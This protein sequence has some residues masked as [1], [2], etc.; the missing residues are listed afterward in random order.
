[1]AKSSIH[2]ERASSGGTKHND[3]TQE[4][5]PD[6]LLPRQYRLKNEVD[7]SAEEAEQKI[8][9]LY[10]TA[11]KN[12][13]KIKGQKLQAT[14]Y[15]WEAVVN[16]NKYHTM[17]DVQQLA[18]ELEKETGFTAVQVAIHRD[19]GRVERGYPIHNFHAHITFFTLNLKNGEQLYRK[20]IKSSERRAIERYLLERGIDKGEPRSR[21]R[22]AFNN[23]VSKEIEARGIKVMDKKR[24]SKL[25]DLT[26]R[27]LGMIRGKRGSNAVRLEHKAYKAKKRDEDKLLAKEIAKQ[28]DL[29][30]EVAQLRKE[31]QEQGAIR[32]DYARLEQLNR[33]LKEQV[34]SKNLTI[35]ELG[36]TVEHWKNNF[37][38]KKIENEKALSEAQE[39][40]LELKATISSEKEE[41]E[42]L[43]Q[44]I[45]RLEY[46]NSSNKY[47]L[48]ADELHIRKIERKLALTRA[49]STRLMKAIGK[50][51][52]RIKKLERKLKSEESS[53]SEALIL[54]A[55]RSE[56]DIQEVEKFMRETSF[57]N[58]SLAKFY[59]SARK[60]Y[61][62]YAKYADDKLLVEDLLRR[63]FD[64]RKLKEAVEIYEKDLLKVL[65]RKAR[66]KSQ[67]FEEDF[68]EEISNSP[69]F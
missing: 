69:R 9:D 10:E 65:P 56:I 33:D 18:K 26:A 47:M 30:A 6:Y 27:T 49:G 7:F 66:F 60:K 11:K 23:N 59:L 8:K 14:S 2:F 63:G 31:L 15:K 1:M 4:P 28:K 21:E 20:T 39:T 45:S 36:R 44:N 19:E 53:K 41:K 52:S 50:L 32:E 57:A 16:L 67:D 48:E 42:L 5:E 46:E 25:Q 12:Y 3:R 22:K 51:R 43:G 24:M 13:L 62:P 61:E 37:N 55:E 68:E 40:I 34:K 29:K 38:A 58:Q 35:E 64:V 54:N 17:Q